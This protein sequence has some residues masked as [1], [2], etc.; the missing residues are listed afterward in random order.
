VHY[1]EMTFFTHQVNGRT[2]GG[3]YRLLGPDEIEI[4]G[5]GILCKTPYAGRDEL[6]VA[7]SV[8]EEFV[9]MQMRTGAQPRP[10]DAADHHASTPR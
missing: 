7:R 1:D 10:L 6:S 2:Y 8:L 9:R 4:M 5:A 3:W